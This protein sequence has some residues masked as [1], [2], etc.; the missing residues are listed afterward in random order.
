M[1]CPSRAWGAAPRGLGAAPR[2][3]CY[4]GFTMSP[5]HTSPTDPSPDHWSATR[6]GWDRDV[7]VTRA[8]ATLATGALLGT[9]G[10]SAYQ[11]A[12]VALPGVSRE[13]TLPMM[14]TAYLVQGGWWW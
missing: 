1:K 2:R 5:S 6:A 9:L 11:I 4:R 7:R 13:M 8:R 12:V 10:L 3:F 14:E